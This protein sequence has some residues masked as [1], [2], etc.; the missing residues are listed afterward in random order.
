VTITIREFWTLFHGMAV[1]A[2]YLLA[3]AGGLS[4]FWGLRRAGL[5]NEGLVERI[6]RLKIGV[7]VMAI[8]CW[9]TVISG[10][11]IVYPWY[12]AKEASSPRSM[13]L[14]SPDTAGWHTFGMEWKEHVAWLAPIL[15]TVVA[16]AVFRYGVE[17]SRRND[18]RR[19]T[20]TFYVLAFLSAAVAG[21]FGALITKAAPI[22]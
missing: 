16:A 9:L 21:L 3:F 10:T 19:M 1:G 20:M 11:Y 14:S 18:L 13:L 17:L 12:R 15:A 7:C 6:R 5:T 4:A 8:T 2:I 22:L